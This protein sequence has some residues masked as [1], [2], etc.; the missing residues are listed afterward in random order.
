MGTF[1][2]NREQDARNRNVHIPAIKRITL[3]VLF[4]F[5]LIQ[6]WPLRERGET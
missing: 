1:I 3:P 2:P 4:F 5:D 6:V